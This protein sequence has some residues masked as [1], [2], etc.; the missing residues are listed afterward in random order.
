MKQYLTRWQTV[1]TLCNL[2]L[3]ESKEITPNTTSSSVSTNHSVESDNTN[4]EETASAYLSSNNSLNESD[5]FKQVKKLFNEKKT[6]NR[7]E[8]KIYLGITKS[9]SRS[10]CIK[11]EKEGCISRVGQ[12]N[13]SILY[14]LNL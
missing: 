2:F 6:L 8:M 10:L 14:A 1:D 11:W 7:V 9:K 4:M 13:R 12:A 5:Y 3:P